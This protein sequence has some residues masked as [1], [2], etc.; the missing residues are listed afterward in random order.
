RNLSRTHFA[1]ATT[2]VSDSESAVVS[3]PARADGP[4]AVVVVLLALGLSLLPTLLWWA[5]IGQL[6]YLADGDELLYL[7]YSSQAYFNHPTSLTDP[8]LPSGG[9]SSLPASQFI[10]AV[11]AARGLGL[12]PLGVD[13]IWRAWAGLSIGL[14]F[15]LLVR[16]FVARPWIAA[17]LAA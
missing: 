16:Q 3:R 7:S 11:L 15:Y 4:A 2:A 9:I 13:L 1:T 17:V 5:R 6:G 14:G 10:P 12:G 8:T